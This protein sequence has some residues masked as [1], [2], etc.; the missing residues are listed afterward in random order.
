MTSLANYI[1]LNFLF[2]ITCIPIITIGASSTAL[3]TVV[4]QEARKENGQ[5]F[6]AYIKAFK[7]NFKQS[8]ICFFI[9]LIC[10][11]V[12]IFNIVFWGE[13]AT[14][15][16]NILLLIIALLCVML[17]LSLIY[18]Y[19]LLARFSNSLKQTLK[20]SILIAISNPMYTAG[21]F[22]IYITVIALCFVL[23]EMKIFMVLLG[24]SFIA[25]CNSM[26]LIRVF[27]F[28]EN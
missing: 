27:R 3:Y 6:S 17:V 11:L 2:L 12:F 13:Q 10:A 28:Y 9:H 23:P 14:V 26:L 15:L 22:L 21:L 24:F 4:M 20:N 1:G 25:Y 8:T 5:I 7:S 16:G 18:S 19:A